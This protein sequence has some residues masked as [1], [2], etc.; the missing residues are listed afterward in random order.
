[1]KYSHFRQM[2]LFYSEYWSYSSAYHFYL[3]IS[4]VKFVRSRKS[5][6]PSSPLYNEWVWKKLL[7]TLNDELMIVFTLNRCNLFWELT[8][9]IHVKK[10]IYKT[11]ITIQPLKTGI[12]IK[13][14]GMC[15]ITENLSTDW[16]FQP[17]VLCSIPFL[18]IDFRSHRPKNY[19]MLFC[20][21]HCIWG[22]F[23]KVSTAFV[24]KLISI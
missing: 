18:D 2:I 7:F 15:Q 5:H 19:L 16:S 9:K 8:R 12:D 17:T 21:F 23:H 11:L 1:M 20:V 24:S 3:K 13:W 22:L 6:F 14:H 4:N 10:W